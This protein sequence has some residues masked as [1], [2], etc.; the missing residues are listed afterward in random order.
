V[1]DEFDNPESHEDGTKPDRPPPRRV[2][3]FS[4]DDYDDDQPERRRRREDSSGDDA[5]ATLIPYRNPK[6]L[7]AYYCGMFTVL[8]LI[9]LVLGP[10]A[11]VLGIMGLRYKKQNPTA[12]GTGHAVVGIVLG[13]LFFPIGLI[14]SAICIMLP[15][16]ALFGDK[17]K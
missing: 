15:L 1:A 6:A 9:G 11:V 12:K 4:D 16:W 14:G 5:V 2:R 10:T 7:I 3:R 13:V 17:H 8:P